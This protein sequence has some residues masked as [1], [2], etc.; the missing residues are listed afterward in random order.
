MIKDIL[1]NAAKYIGTPYVWGGESKSEGGFD[2]SGYIYKVL[3]DSNIKVARDT[4]Q[5][6][7]NRFKNNEVKAVTAG[8]LL[9][10]GKSKSKISHIAIALNDSKMYESIG[11]RLNTKFNK[12]KGVTL[13]NINRRKDLVAICTIEQKVLYYPKYA[14]VATTL[15]NMLKCV[16]APHGSVKNRARLALVNGIDNYSGSYN[17]NME[18]IRLVKSGQLRRV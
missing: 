1:A 16:G 13:S 4:A 12:G 15:D 10:F 17:Q 6:Y 8:A 3:N 18:L 11:N 9:F 7:Y 2:C 14:G 5:G